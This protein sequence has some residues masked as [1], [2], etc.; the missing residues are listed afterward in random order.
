MGGTRWPP[1]RSTAH[2]T[3]PRFSLGSRRSLADTSAERADVAAS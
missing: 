3:R 1:E 2:R